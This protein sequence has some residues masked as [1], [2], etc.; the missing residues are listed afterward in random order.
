MTPT[1]ISDEHLHLNNKLRKPIV[2]KMRRDRI[3]RSIEQLKALM[4]PEFLK[5]QSDSKLEKADILEMTVSFMTHQ[6]SVLDSSSH[7]VNQGFS[8]CV[9]DIEHF[10]STHDTQKTQSQRRLLK[11]FQN[12]QTPSEQIRRESVLPQL[13]STHHNT[14]NKQMNVNK[15]AIWRPT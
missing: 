7:A 11:H 4:D 5:Q 13:S 8:R 9:H 12:L 10:L 2:E 6:Q 1:I 3:N 14:I 15:S